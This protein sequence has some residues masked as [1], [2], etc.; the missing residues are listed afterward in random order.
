MR[1]LNKFEIHVKPLKLVQDGVGLGDSA[2]AVEKEAIGE[3]Q[4]HALGVVPD[5]LQLGFVGFQDADHLP[6][7]RG[8]TGGG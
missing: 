8:L 1:Q 5:Q 2:R 7:G 6:W 4:R 3:A